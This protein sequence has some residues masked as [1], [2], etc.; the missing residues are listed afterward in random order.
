[1]KRELRPA[2]AMI[3]LIFAI[4]VIGIT[5]L[6]APLLVSQATSSSMTSFQQESVAMA[7]SHT[8]AVM[9]YEWDEENT[10]IHAGKILNVTS[11]DADLD[12]ST[13]T[14]ARGATARFPNARRRQFD[15]IATPLFATA[16]LGIDTNDSVDDIDDFIV[17][18]LHLTIYSTA[19][20]NTDRGDYIDK[21]ITL[22]TFVL[23]GND[24]ATYNSGTGIFA[25]SQPFRHAAIPNGSTT[26]IKLITVRLTSNNVNDEFKDKQITLNAFMCNIGTGR[27]LK[28]GGY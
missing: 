18:P 17:K 16:H 2:I 28:R 4:V 8:S 19:I 7:A 26:N 10:G 14:L 24:A 25:F 12:Q 15:N 21:N 27:P 11:G 9:T 13:G 6:S 5:L 23:Y 20:N 22:N 3:E 1:M